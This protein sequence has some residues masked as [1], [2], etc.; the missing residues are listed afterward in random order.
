LKQDL[1]NSVIVRQVPF[2]LMLSPREASVRISAHSEMVRE[3]P[4][5]PEVVESRVVRLVTARR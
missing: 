5:P 3:V 1:S 2:T 4:P